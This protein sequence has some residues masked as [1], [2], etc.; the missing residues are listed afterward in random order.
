MFDGESLP[1]V[2]AYD[3]LIVMGGPMNIYDY[4]AH[5]WLEREK[6]AIED[7]IGGGKV[8]VGVCLGAQLLADALGAKV[9]RNTFKEIG[10]YPVALTA[11]GQHHALT[12]GVPRRFTAFHWHGDTFDLPE[13]AIRLAESEACRQQMF[14][15]DN[16]VLGLQCHLEMTEG[17]VADLIKHCRD[18][19]VVDKYVQSADAMRA[20]K[21]HLQGANTVLD[22][23]FDRLDAVTQSPSR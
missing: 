5:P 15:Y 2:D 10:W 6:L 12:G 21:S 19:I 7:A 3:W 23:L 16:R 9:T 20:G 1:G 8:V 11:Q 13:G 22:C 18:E 4:E 17:G 14:V